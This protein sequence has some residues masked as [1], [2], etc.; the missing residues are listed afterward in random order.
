MAVD[1]NEHFISSDKLLEKSVKIIKTINKKESV[2]ELQF[3]FMTAM[4]N[5][6]YKGSKDDIK[7][8]LN[9]LT[10]KDLFNILE[11]DSI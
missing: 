9:F 10:L 2:Q 8:V 1:Y 3:V 11:T 4:K 7:K 5:L 6:M